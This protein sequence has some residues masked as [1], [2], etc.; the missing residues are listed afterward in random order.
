MSSLAAAFTSDRS[1]LWGLCYRMTGSA[2][3]ADDIVQET[4][5]RALEQPPAR[6]DEPWRP[7]LVRVAMNLARDALRR[8]RRRRYAGPWLPA[9]VDTGDEAAMPAV[10][11]VLPGGDTTAGR[12][13]LL[14][15]VSYAFLIA[16]EALTPQQRGVLLLR[17]VFDYDVRETAAALGISEV[18]VKVTHH[19]ARARMA[20]Y[21]HRRC[22]PTRGLQERTRTALERL[23]GAL[24]GG[25]VR[26]VERL[27]AADV[28]AL[29]DGGGEFHAARVPLV[30]PERV[31]RF[32]TNIATRGAFGARSEF[33]MLNGLPALVTTLPC[34][35]PGYAPLVVTRADVDADGRIARLY[36]VLATRKLT[37][38]VAARD[39]WTPH[40]ELA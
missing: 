38:I 8:R 7:W 20:A 36:S 40:G 31:A 23:L 2:A 21:D 10:E 27:L 14:E 15:S 32:Y 26:H 35:P 25:D 30:G 17:D 18:S 39:A 24:A 34:P 5:A 11:A 33:R 13:D 22:I 29:S 4:F 3:D 19:R 37:A 6:T 16:L 12:Y 1:L 28:R 9:P